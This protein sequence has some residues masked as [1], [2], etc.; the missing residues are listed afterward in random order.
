MKAEKTN[1][2]QTERY[3]GAIYE[4]YV[5]SLVKPTKIKMS[6]LLKE[7]RV[8]YTLVKVLTENKFIKKTAS[9]TYLWIGKE[10]TK[11]IAAWL[12]V[13]CRAQLAKDQAESERRKSEK[14]HRAELEA[15]PEPT[16]PNLGNPMIIDTTGKTAH[17]SSG[18]LITEENKQNWFQRIG[19]RIKNLF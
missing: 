7:H 14:K 1:Q 17:W 12:V 18:K 5:K 8:G 15:K 13:L 6:S 11:R 2:T 16:R 19:T 4:I 10:P 9:N 3:F